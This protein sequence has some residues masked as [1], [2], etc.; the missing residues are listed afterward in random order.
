MT[1]CSSGFGSYIRQQLLEQGHYVYGVGLN[2]PD[3]NLDF[4]EH[5]DFWKEDV[6]L[7]FSDAE[8]HL[9]GPIDVLINNAGCTHIDFIENHTL[10]DFNRVMQ[11]NLTAPFLF[12]K[13]FCKRAADQ[14][15]GRVTRFTV[16]QEYRVVNTSSMG[17]AIA[18]RGSPGYC[19]SKAGLEAMSRVFAKELAGKLP[20]YFYTICPGGIE[21]TEMWQH[22][23]DELVAKRGMTREEAIR[24]NTQSPLGRNCEFEEVWEVFNFAVN[25]A[26]HYMSGT[27]LRMPG[28]M[29]V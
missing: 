22:V 11:V 21:N 25:K 18:L 14:V 23:I 8:R 9:A 3:Y 17:T 13:E 1:G 19:A 6:S 10:E 15:Y 29:G 7:C 28:A 27:V 12:S 24:Y 16:P 26:P 5:V 2:G 4:S 20:V